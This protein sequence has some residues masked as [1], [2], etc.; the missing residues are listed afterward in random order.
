MEEQKRGNKSRRNKQRDKIL[1]EIQV[2][3]K[4]VQQEK[5]G[6]ICS[7]WWRQAGRKY[8]DETKRKGLR[9]VQKYW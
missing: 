4:E 5:G 2:D 7:D 8:R 3:R 1:E 9:E 6:E